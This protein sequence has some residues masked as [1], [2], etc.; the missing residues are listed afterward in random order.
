MEPMEYLMAFDAAVTLAEKLAPKIQEMF[1]S[2]EISVEQQQSRL[3]KLALMRDPNSSYYKGPEMVRSDE[4]PT[5][6][7]TDAASSGPT[8]SDA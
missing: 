3:D 2:G 4:Q 5:L 1:K 6:P 7:A 8:A